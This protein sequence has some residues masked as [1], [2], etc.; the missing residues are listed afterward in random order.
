M[1]WKNDKYKEVP[2]EADSEFQKFNAGREKEYNPFID[3]QIYRMLNPET[4]ID[5]IRNFIVFETEET[6]TIKNICRYQQYRAVNK[7]ID[8]VVSGEQK[9]QG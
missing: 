4:Y 6:A 7:I 8:R 3:R 1:E 9:K 5:L 2:I